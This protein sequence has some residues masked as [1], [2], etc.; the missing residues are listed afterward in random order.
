MVFKDEFVA[1]KNSA[2]YKEMA[3]VLMDNMSLI[4]AEIVNRDVPSNDRD[5]YL[6]GILAGFRSVLEWQPEFADENHAEV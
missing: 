1:F 4:A 3:Q 6:K 5:Q 2:V